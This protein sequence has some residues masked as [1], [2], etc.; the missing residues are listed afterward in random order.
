MSTAWS[1]VLASENLP[2]LSNSIDIV[3]FCF[4]PKITQNH[5]ILE[6]FG[7]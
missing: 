3:F 2:I 5:A 7:N 4:K 6:A 1:F